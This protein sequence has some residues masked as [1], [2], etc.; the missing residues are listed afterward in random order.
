V[1]LFY[2]L[3][4]IVVISIIIMTGTSGDGLVRDSKKWSFKTE[5]MSKTESNDIKNLSKEGRSPYLEAQE[6]VKQYL[7]RK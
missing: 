2:K 4:I 6:L 1:E 5:Y 3:L 7:F